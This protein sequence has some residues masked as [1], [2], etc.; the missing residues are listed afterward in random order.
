MKNTTLLRSGVAVLILSTL[1]TAVEQDQGSAPPL[2]QQYPGPLATANF[3]KIVSGNFNGDIALDAVVMDG[4]LPKLVVSPENLDNAIP[5]GVNANDIA[6]IPPLGSASKDSLLTV[7]TNGLVRHT[8]NTSTGAWTPFTLRGVSTRWFN[9]KSVIVAQFD[10]TPNPDIAGIGANGH[11]VYVES[12]NTLHPTYTALPTFNVP[13]QS[14]YGIVAVDW[15][16][17]GDIANTKELALF[18]NVGVL[19]YEP[20]GTYVTSTPWSS[21]TNRGAAVK[22]P[23]WSTERL[24]MVDVVGGV[25]QLC[26]WGPSGLSGPW[27]LGAAGVVSIAAGDRDSDGDS[28]LVLG[29]NTENKIYVLD[30]LA[31]SPQVAPIFDTNSVMKL[32][33]GYPTRNP[34]FNHAG[35][36]LA[37]FDGDHI[38][39]ALAP[40]QGNLSGI[41]V[42]ST[43]PL[44]QLGI[45][46]PLTYRVGITS[47]RFLVAEHQVEVTFNAPASVLPNGPDGPAQLAVS[48]WYT[49]DL[50]VGTLTVP[51]DVSYLTM[52]TA[53]TPTVFV[54]N[55]D[56]YDPD[57]DPGIYS[58]VFRQVTK[59]NG[60]ITEQTPSRVALITGDVNG[61][62]L[63]NSAASSN[64]TPGSRIPVG[65]DPWTGGAIFDPAAP[66][67]DPGYEP[68]PAK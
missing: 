18:T 44:V 43:L 40:A 45:A 53:S 3:G 14:I 25:D 31:A 58:M 47:I 55:I 26:V 41:A 10:D 50:G 29:V 64:W 51:I 57:T 28:D 5:L 30:N 68:E 36:A 63:K 42:N 32:A 8:R 20:N 35:I 33:F 7:G 6:M 65:E 2:N 15:N 56:G 52:P 17:S 49:P 67:N 60:L 62:S 38:L 21:L 46:S 61:L 12:A 16:V 11:E 9:A 19:I 23:L 1:V 34:A 66:S 48:T 13:V 22:S 39:D 4:T 24:A 27:P 37:D 54:L 59:T